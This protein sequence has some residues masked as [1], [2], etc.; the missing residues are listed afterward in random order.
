MTITTIYQSTTEVKQDIID[1]IQYEAKSQMQHRE[2][3]KTYYESNFERFLL[4]LQ[5]FD[6]NTVIEA[7][8]LAK[9][10]L[11]QQDKFSE[12]TGAPFNTRLENATAKILLDEL[13]KHYIV[14]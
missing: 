12:F 3:H 8:E 5:L 9:N 14:H 4:H 6:T 13:M 7:M 10:T 2:K 1:Y 11:I